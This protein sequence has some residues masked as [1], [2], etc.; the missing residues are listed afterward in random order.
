M[1]REKAKAKVYQGGKLYGT[2]TTAIGLQRVMYYAR[3]G[4]LQNTVEIHYR[5]KVYEN[6]EK[7][8]R[9]IRGVKLTGPS[10]NTFT[11]RNL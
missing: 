10:G 6:C 4:P 2:A 3:C 11:G 5:G 7:A 8:G 1:R 9:G